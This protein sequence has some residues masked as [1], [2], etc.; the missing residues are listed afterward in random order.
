MRWKIAQLLDKLPGQCWSD[1]VDWVYAWDRP[2]EDRPALW[3]PLR[4]SCRSDA[5]R[6]GSCYCGKLGD[7]GGDA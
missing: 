2:K 7:R 4:D 6:C 1:L 3:S 5:T